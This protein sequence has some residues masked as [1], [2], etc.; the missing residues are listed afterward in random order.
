MTARIRLMTFNLRGATSWDGWNMWPMRIPLVL[1][2]LRAYAPDVTGF[3]E[4]HPLNL[5]ALRR[6]RSKG[7]YHGLRSG[8]RLSGPYN[9]LCWRTDSVRAGARGA[10]YLSATPERRSKS[11][12]SRH[13]RTAT[14]AELVTSAGAFRCVNVHLDNASRR[15]RVEAVRLILHR[16]AAL[17]GDVPTVLLGDFNQDPAGQVYELLTAGGLRDA[18]LEAGREDDEE[19]FTIHRFTG[20]RLTGEGRI[21]WVFVSK[22][23]DVGQA[24]IVKNGRAPR[25]PSDHFPVL[26]DLRLRSSPSAPC[27]RSLPRTPM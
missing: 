3:Q 1:D 16:L 9:P 19:A 17:G 12:G 23:F 5:L 20:K 10:F 2:L 15:A 14:W 24:D 22:H 21:D 11:W 13:I 4:A 26:V 8:D 6:W 27:S 18:W 25:Y 7:W